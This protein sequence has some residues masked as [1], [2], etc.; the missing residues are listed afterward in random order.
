LHF[1]EGSTVSRR[2][3]LHF[4]HFVHQTPVRITPISPKSNSE[5][6][7]NEHVWEVFLEYE[8]HWIPTTGSLPMFT[9]KYNTNSKLF[10][11]VTQ[12]SAQ[13]L[14]YRIQDLPYPGFSRYEFHVCCLDIRLDSHSVVCF[15][16]VDLGSSWFFLLIFLNIAC[17]SP[18]FISLYMSFA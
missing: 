9:T 11:F 13:D 3:A 10:Q 16:S 4:L 5:K 6:E 18:L 12:D 2:M 14:I 1:T 7:F 8:V 17:G 15:H